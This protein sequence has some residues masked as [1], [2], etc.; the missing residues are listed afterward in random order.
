M[1]L[2]EQFTQSDTENWIFSS[3]VFNHKN[4][5]VLLYLIN[6]QIILMINRQIIKPKTM[7][8]NSSCIFLCFIND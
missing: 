1:I 5:H 8:S 7:S 2:I 3:N 6:L 4:E